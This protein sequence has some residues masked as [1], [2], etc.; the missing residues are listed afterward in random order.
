MPVYKSDQ[1]TK[2]GRKY[3]FKVRYK[4]NKT[5]RLIQYKSK[6]YSTKRDAE[7]AEAVFLINSGEFNGGNLTFND[8]AIEFLE[9]QKD[10]MRQHPYETL[11]RIV[12]YV[13][14]D[15]GNIRIDALTSAQY[16]R[17]YNHIKDLSFSKKYSNQILGS[18]KRLVNF[19]SKRYGISTTVPFVFDNYKDV[20][21]S[22]KNVDFYTISE[23]NMFI[24]VVDDI[25]FKL[26]F[27]TMFYC[28][29]RPGEANALTWNEI[30]FSDRSITINKSVD[31]RS[32]DYI[33]GPPKTAAGYRTIP[34]SNFLKSQL[35]DLHTFWS[36]ADGYND[37]WFVF[38]GW[39]PFPN[40]TMQVKKNKYIEK[41]NSLAKNK[42]INEHQSDDPKAYLF[43]EPLKRIRL[44]DL[45]HSCASMLINEL[46][47]PITSV[48]KYLGHESPDITLK[49]Y[50]H[51]YKEKLT[52]I[53]KGIDN[54][55][56]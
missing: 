11:S 51:F 27:M 52:D 49:V 23:F 36:N 46:K 15:L 3:Y 56:K 26:L 34:I 19:C 10:R 55:H 41:Y 17:F 45:R 4:N 14:K 29:L 40:N 30:N 6:K 28:G 20:N 42:Y 38:G 53:A 32:S 43:K 18:A 44:H 2:D 21:K 50:S 24:S 25:R 1:P 5:G 37:N 47:V 33:I 39:K 31:T 35:E 13:T 16:Q 54:M 22:D 7:K 8:I 9:Y 12:S 48:S